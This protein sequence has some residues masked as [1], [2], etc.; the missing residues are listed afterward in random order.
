MVKRKV[1]STSFDHEGRSQGIHLMLSKIRSKILWVV[2]YQQSIEF[3][4]FLVYCIV[5]NQDKQPV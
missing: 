4:L 3:Y 1:F 2:E 5:K